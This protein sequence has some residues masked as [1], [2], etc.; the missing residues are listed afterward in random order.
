MYWF[1]KIGK[2]TDVFLSSRVRLA[3]NLKDY[4]FEPALCETA[5]KEIIEKVKGALSECGYAEEAV[6][7]ALSE[8]RI[9]SRE[10]AAKKAPHALL[11]N[12][13]EDTYVMVCEE[14]HLRIQCVK[15]G[16][17]LRGALE[18]AVS[19]DEK[20]DEKCTVAFDEKLGYLTHCPTNLG[21]G[22]RASVMMHLPALSVT[23]RLK[24]LENQLIK[25]GFTV[26]GC[27]GEGSEGLGDLYQIS[28]SASLGLTEEEIIE[29][30]ESCAKS[31]A[32]AERD[33]RQRLMR[34]KGDALRDKIMR[35]LGVAKYAHLL[36][37]KEMY[38]LYS[39]IRLGISLG[40]IE[41]DAAELDRLLMSCLPYS[42]CEGKDLS[43]RERDKK[44]AE[45][46]AKV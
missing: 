22:M 2:D 33:M 9:I 25:L 39:D 42:L 16:F 30:L 3:R 36:T 8:K 1:D 38:S 44:R 19:C 15:A 5:A 14:D 28:N 11:I 40:I 10:L 27:E 34:E 37:T 41:K 31:V 17:D 21:T 26:R 20:I 24:S 46:F 35:S 12:K 13:N 4:P 45:R 29:K 7:P 23:G 32:E 6:T 43:P 18:G